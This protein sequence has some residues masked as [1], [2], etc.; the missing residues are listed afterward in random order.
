VKSKSNEKQEKKENALSETKEIIDEIEKTQKK[1][2]NNLNA[3]NEVKSKLI[4]N[5]LILIYLFIH[6]LIHRSQF[7]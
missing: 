5:F 3:A 7:K 6:S 1:S 4:L 2:E